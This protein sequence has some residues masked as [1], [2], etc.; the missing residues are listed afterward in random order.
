MQPKPKTKK[1][2]KLLI[3]LREMPCVKCGQ[4]GPSEVDHIKTV[5]SGG[6]DDINNCWPMCRG[7][8]VEKHQLGL[9]RLVEQNY[10]LKRV[11]LLRGW[12]FDQLKNKW[13]RY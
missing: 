3:L 1:D 13:V 10:H 6:E 9:T 8:H 11:L 7:C 12:S 4:P 2:A 5:G